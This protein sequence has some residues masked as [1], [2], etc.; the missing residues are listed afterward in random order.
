MNCPQTKFITK[1]D[2]D[3]TLD[4]E[5]VKI[6]LFFRKNYLFFSQLKKTLASK[7]GSGAG[8][9]PDILECPSVIR[10]MRPLKQ[11]HS[12]TI[13]GK[14]FIDEEELS[15]RVYPDLCFGWLYV[16]TPR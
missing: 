5:K 14:F 16:T 10:N 3:V 12:G 6:L 15:R 2:D 9:A 11:R 8:P 13:M 7:Y 1:T 4:V